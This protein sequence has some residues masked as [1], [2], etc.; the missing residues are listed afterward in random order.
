[1][2]TS[3]LRESLELSSSG[4]KRSFL[5]SWSG[6]PDSTALLHSL[7]SLRSDFNFRLAAFHLNFGLRGEESIQDETFC[8]QKAKEW[9]LALVVYRAPKGSFAETAIQERARQLRL[10]ILQRVL[11]SWEC[12]EAHQ[13]DDQVETFL[14]RLFR[15]TGLDGLAGMKSYDLRMGRRVRRPFLKVTKEEIL[16]YLDSKKLE[17]R[18]DQTN[19]SSNYDRNFIRNILL[20]QIKH[21]FPQVSSSISRLQEQIQEEKGFFERML[22]E[23]LLTRAMLQEDPPIMSREYLLKLQKALRHRLLHRFF[24][25]RFGSSL[26][27]QQ[28]LELDEKLLSGLPFVYNAPKGVVVRCGGSRKRPLEHIEFDFSA[29]LR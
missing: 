2:L 23:E 11:P 5:V 22:D 26:S 3:I 15:G 16:R 7:W 10:R 29:V 20:P 13:A 19:L 17:Y 24:L 12:L 21:R 18:T 1:M 9:D 4:P 6:G 14:F 8:R 25:L 28:I 27:R